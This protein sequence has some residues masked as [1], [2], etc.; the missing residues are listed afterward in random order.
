MTRLLYTLLLILCLSGCNNDLIDVQ[1]SVP[2]GEPVDL[3]LSFGAKGSVQAVISRQTMPYL[4][5]ESKVWN[6]YVFVFD[7]EGKKIYG[8][9][10]DAQNSEADDTNLA[11]NSWYVSNPSKDSD[12]CT[13]TVNIRT[14]SK[15]DCS[16]YAIAN[17]NS[18]EIN[19]SPEALDLIYN[20]EELQNRVV[21][22]NQQLVERSGFFLMTGAL[23][24]VNTGT[25]ISESLKLTRLD[26]K[27]RFWVKTG[28]NSGIEKF[29]LKNWQ[30]VNVPT[31][32]YLLS[33]DNRK[34]SADVDSTY[35]TSKVKNPEDEEVLDDGSERY[36]FSFYMLE[37]GMTPK[38]TPASYS[39]RERQEK[40]AA[41]LNGAWEYAN[42]NSTYVVISGRV[43]MK[44]D[45]LTGHEGATLNAN[46]R[47]VIHLGDFSENKWD[48][49]ATE[50][51]TSYTYNVTINGVNDI[52]VEVET[53][54]DDTE[55]ITEN[56][57]GATGEVTIALQ[58]IFD[59]DAHYT[60]C[61]L[62]FDAKY[63]KADDVTWYV[64]TPFSEGSPYQDQNQGV[65]I[66]AGLD[67]EWIE[68]RVNNKNEDGTYSDKRQRYIPH[69]T[70]TD[71]NG[72]SYASSDRK[73]MYVD[74]LVAYLKKQKAAY[75][76]NPEDSDFDKNGKLTVTAFVNEFY[77]EEHPITGEKSS[78]LWK[79]FVNRDDMRLM[80]ILSDT[81][82]SLD[83]ES[84]VV[85]SSFTI[86]QR[87][88]QTVYNHKHPDLMTAWG[89]EHFDEHAGLP[90]NSVNVWTGDGRGNT[91]DYNGRLNSLI[92]LGLANSSD[93]IFIVGKKWSDFLDVEAINE[94][95]ELL[96]AY[97]YLRYTCLTRNRD[98]NGDGFIDADELRWYMPAIKQLIGLWMGAEG[99]QNTARLYTRTAEQKASN[100]AT[101]WRQH[102]VSSTAIQTIGYSNSPLVVWAEEGC[103][104]GGLYGSAD[105]AK[106]S[107]W[108]T[109]CVRNLGMDDETDLTKVPTDYVKMG[110]TDKKPTFDLTYLNEKCI[111][112]RVPDGVDLVYSD[113]NSIQNKLYWKFEATAED[114]PTFTAITFANMQEEVNNFL[115][116]NRFCPKGYRLPNQRELILM[117]YY[118]SQN[119]WSGVEHS[120]SHTYYSYGAHGSKTK[121]S[122]KNKYGWGRNRQA[123]VGNI[124]MVSNEKST[125][126]RAVRDLAL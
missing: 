50:R 66:T 28:K 8:R 82:E 42:D 86:Q 13:G 107:K 89:V 76:V 21:S 52:R 9:F 16:I 85:G 81:K 73:T 35:F 53:S 92:E 95:K 113:E 78:T 102:V 91:D 5:D 90:Y 126:I 47:Y 34:N 40:D 18:A 7:S 112:Y 37:N 122:E 32:S 88:I 65:D 114:C 15:R 25:D 101:V 67:Y 72:A 100:D 3:R 106:L 93:K 117:R 12:E 87:S 6:L 108:E 43:V 77:Y 46:V 39:D 79:E 123:G 96:S 20:E 55:G 64:R 27:V 11:T 44:T 1:P 109:K 118:C 105:W 116:S 57:P 104:T 33:R 70:K 74:E 97:K 115:G 36:G 103:S 59:C 121:E 45:A 80:H 58:E 22:L 38:K 69:H 14:I 48:N 62:N 61:T 83:K 41:G 54:N 94:D 60:T 71:K 75:D 30:V 120:F 19:V 24:S 68:F 124:F 98:N 2:E 17:V 56:A 99:V 84:T 31:S 63:I 10:F 110:G 119:F 125:Q 111:R 26:A 49:F 4:S 23:K 29:E 51:N